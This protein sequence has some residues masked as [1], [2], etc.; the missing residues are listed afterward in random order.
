LPAAYPGAHALRFLLRLHPGRRD[1]LLWI[2]L[3]IILVLLLV[4]GVGG[5]GRFYGRR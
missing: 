3:I 4:G 1:P 2:I 5:R